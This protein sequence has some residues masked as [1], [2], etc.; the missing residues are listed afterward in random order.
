M[1]HGSCPMV[2]RSGNQGLGTG[3]GAA[4]NLHAVGTQTGSLNLLPPYLPLA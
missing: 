3:M 2:G 1:Q 4:V